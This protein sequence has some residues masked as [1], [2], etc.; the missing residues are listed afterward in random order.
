MKITKTIS[1]KTEK[2]QTIPVTDL[3]VGCVYMTHT[4]DL[5]QVRKIDEKT[6]TLHLYNISESCTSYIS[7]D[8]NLII[9]KIR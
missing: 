9:K 3:N 1:Q 7:F 2:I 4:K 6:K 5:V 8:N